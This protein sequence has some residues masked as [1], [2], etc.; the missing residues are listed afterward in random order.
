MKSLRKQ[1]IDLLLSEHNSADIMFGNLIAR[2][3]F[4]RE[5]MALLVDTEHEYCRLFHNSKYGMKDCFLRLTDVLGII[6]S[7]EDKGLVYI[8]DSSYKDGLELFFE[9]KEDFHEAQIP[10]EYYVCDDKKL[11]LT[12]SIQ[13][14]I[15]EDTMGGTILPA[16]MY[17]SLVHVF[18][19]TIYPTKGLK[20]Y[21]DRGY[22]T[23][24]EAS[25]RRSRF[26]AWVAIIVSLIIGSVSIWLK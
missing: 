10:G 14:I 6:I 21:V 18:C 7:L 11:V 15:G 8:S 22:R 4:Q 5:E 26:I 23:S 20:E 19:G 13:A 9:A 2:I 24:E 25:S 3:L 16:R 1:G 12:E 17:S